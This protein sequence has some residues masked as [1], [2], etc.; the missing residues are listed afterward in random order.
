MSWH[1]LRCRSGR[2]FL[3][4]TIAPYVSASSADATAIYALIFMN[5]GPCV[6]TGFQLE[7]LQTSFAWWQRALRFRALQIGSR[8]DAFVAGLA[9]GLSSL[10]KPTGLAVMA[11]YGWRAS[12]HQSSSMKSALPF[13][14]CAAAG[15]AIPPALVLAWTIKAGLLSEM[16]GLIHQIRLYTNE[17]PFP[18]TDLVKPFVALML[19]G[20]P[21]L[22][23]ALVSMEQESSLPHRGRLCCLRCSGLRLNSPAW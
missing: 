2:H 14:F 10:I 11:A 20:L 6:F 22:A 4:R 5:F 13:L 9:A 12:D 18:L 23:V 21:F 7:T 17:T 16:P 15:A 8:R 3:R 1:K 19:F